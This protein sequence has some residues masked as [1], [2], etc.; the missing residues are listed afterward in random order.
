MPINIAFSKIDKSFCK[1]YIAY[2]IISID[3]ITALLS[4]P[5][6]NGLIRYMVALDDPDFTF[7]FGAQLNDVLAIC[8]AIADDGAYIYPEAESN[9][10]FNSQ[11]TQPAASD[12]WISVEDQLPQLGVDVM[13]QFEEGIA[14]AHL[15]RTTRGFE[16]SCDGPRWAN[17]WKPIPKTKLSDYFK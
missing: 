16:W 5:T 2:P 4:I 17:K 6:E 14:V 10:L 3:N 13:C 9:P 8:H 11:N 15:Q 12:E 1:Q 7:C